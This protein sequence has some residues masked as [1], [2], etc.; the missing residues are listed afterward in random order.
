MTLAWAG[1]LFSRADIT[2]GSRGAKQVGVVAA[3]LTRYPAASNIRRD[4]LA[5]LVRYVRNSSTC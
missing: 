4:A 1:V 3:D 2:H 5:D